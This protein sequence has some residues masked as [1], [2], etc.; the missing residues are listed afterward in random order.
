W[1]ADHVNV[2]LQSAFANQTAFPVTLDARHDLTLPAE[3]F[4]ITPQDGGLIIRARDANGEFYGLLEVAERVTNRADKIDAATFLKDFPPIRETPYASFRADNPFIHLDRT[5]ASHLAEKLHLLKPPL[6]FED[7]AMWKQYLDMLGECRFNVMDLH[8]AYN[9][10]A[11]TFHNLLPLLVSVPE[12]P[13]VGNAAIQKRNLSDL[14]KLISYGYKRGVTLALMNYSAK[15]DGLSSSELPDYTAKAVCLLLQKLPKLRLV[16]FRVGESG[17][18][19]QFFADAYVK[20]IVASGRKDV[21]LYTRSWKTT[22][23][24][25]DALATTY[26]GPTDVEVKYNGEQLGLP[27]QAILGPANSHYSYGDFLDPGM[28]YGK[29]WQIRANGT[30]RYWTWADTNFIRRTV[31]TVSFGGA[32]G[33]S[34]EPQTAYFDFAASTYYQSS[35]DRQTYRYIWQKFWPWYLAWGRLGYNPDLPEKTLIAAYGR[36]FGEEGPKIYAALQASGP[37]IP[38]IL[39][40]RFTGPDQRNMSPETQSGAFDTIKHAA[41]TPLSFAE[42]APMDPRS[43]AGIE[44]WVDEKLNG[45]TDGRIGPKRIGQLLGDAAEATQKQLDAMSPTSSSSGPARLAKIDLSCA[46]WLGQ[47]YAQRTL[48]TMNLGYALKS[49]SKA[50]YETA[51]AHLTKSRAAWTHLSEIADSAFA[52]LNNPLIGQMKF[53]WSSEIERLEQ[54][55][56]TIAERWAATPEKDPASPLSFTPVEKGAALG[57]SVVENTH[58]IHDAAVEISCRLEPLGQVKSAAVWVKT[59][60]SET[61]WKRTPMEAQPNGSFRAIVPCPPSGIL[62]LLEIT[63]ASGDMAQFPSPLEAMPYWVVQ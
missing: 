22:P 13:N 41:V 42:N 1:A 18:A 26:G 29:I 21:H 34:L 48:G 59:F 56:A 35:E 12:Y 7:L 33:F 27:Y 63:N 32:K 62:Y 58:K 16:G 53:R 9:V 57:I 36:H 61:P 38:M 4:T 49:G 10:N 11:T 55:D 50:D 25:L 31:K 20:G 39:A 24:E 2:A 45:K 47:Y 8:G 17:E 44:E 3:S 40:Y 6:L 54:L 19:A 30:H 46:S 52:P 43:F 51:L 14:R 5:G 28:H 37:I 23:S 15:V 60:P